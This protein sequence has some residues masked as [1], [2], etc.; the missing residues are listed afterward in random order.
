MIAYL[1]GKLADVAEENLVLEVNG[2]GYN[3]KVNGRTTGMLPRIGEEIKI[4][5]YTA[6][7]EDAISLFGFLTKDDLEMFRLLITVSGIGP[8]GAL[9]VLSVLD[10]DGLRFAIVS[11]DAKAIAKAPGVG[12]KTA[13]RVIIDLKD[14][15]SIEDT[16]VQKEKKE[17]EMQGQASGEVMKEAAE[18]LTALGYPASEALRAV[19]QVEN[20]EQM[21]V[22]ELLKQAL[23]KLF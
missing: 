11:G 13:E 9:A 2:I 21:E 6:V 22:E 5:T 19:K 23:K 1:R 16:F 17:W 3:V 4:Y 20:A 14:K 7:R 12:A 10:A 15:V 8:K 18:A